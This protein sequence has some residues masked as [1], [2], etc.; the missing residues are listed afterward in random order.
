MWSPSLI[1][2]HQVCNSESL[3]PVFCLALLGLPLRRQIC[4]FVFWTKFWVYHSGLTLPSLCSLWMTL[5]ASC[6][7]MRG[8]R[9]AFQTPVVSQVARGW[10]RIKF[11]IIFHMASLFPVQHLAREVKYSMQKYPVLYKGVWVD[12]Q[13]C[14]C[15]WEHRCRDVL[16][17]GERDCFG[18]GNR[19]KQR[20][21]RDKLICSLGWLSKLSQRQKLQQKH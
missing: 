1:R 17:A 12:E 4:C 21:P 11:F 2:E 5:F 3:I 14:P 15:G 20:T 8:K 19:I 7:G 6:C 18:G 16:W 9:K 13:G 10:G